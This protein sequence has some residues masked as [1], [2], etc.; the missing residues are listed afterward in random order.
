ARAGTVSATGIDSALGLYV[1]ISHE[2][3][4]RTVYGHLS[5]VNVELNQLVLSGTIIGAV[6]STGLSTGP[7]LHFEIRSGGS[8]RDPSSYIPGMAP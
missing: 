8:T 6:G 5:A 4:W 7:H 2:G 3:N 1:I